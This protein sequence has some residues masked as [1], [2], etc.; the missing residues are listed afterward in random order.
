MG[1]G[2]GALVEV[3]WSIDVDAVVEVVSAAVLASSARVL[4]GDGTLVIGNSSPPVSS[5]LLSF[6]GS[7]F[8]SDERDSLSEIYRA[9]SK[10]L[11]LVKTYVKSALHSPQRSPSFRSF[12]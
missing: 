6:G 12:L 2:L 3:W 9:F 4:E 11:K 7:W 5:S 10:W 8:D 1:L